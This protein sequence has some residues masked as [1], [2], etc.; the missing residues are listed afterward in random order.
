MAKAVRRHAVAAVA[1]LGASAIAVTPIAR[2]TPPAIHV[3]NL[4]TSLAASVA[5]TPVN[6]AYALANVP[7]NQVQAV[8]QLAASLFHSGT[9]WVGSAANV[10]GTDAADPGKWKSLTNLLVPFPAMSNVLGEQLAMIAAAELPTSDSCDAESCFPIFP[11]DPITG[12]TDLDRTIQVVAIAL[13]LKPLAVVNNWFQVPLSELMSG[14]TFPKVVSPSGPVY[15]GF[16][17]EGTHPDP[18]TGEPLMPWSGQTFTWHPLDPLV[19][20][21]NSL[22]ATPPP[23]ADA[24]KIVTGQQVFSAFQA[25]LAGIVV[26]F[27]PFVPGSPSCGACGDALWTTPE[28][29][30]FIGAHPRNALIDEWLTRVENGTVNEPTDA[31]VAWNLKTLEKPFFTFDPVTTAKINTLL[32][33]IHPVL[34]DIAAHSGLLAPADTPALLA[35]IERILG[36]GGSSD[37]VRPPLA[38]ATRLVSTSDVPQWGAAMPISPLAPDF[39]VPVAVSGQAVDNVSV[40]RALPMAG[41]TPDSE[42]KPGEESDQTTSSS[43]DRTAT[44]STHG[45]RSTSGPAGGLTGDDAVGTANTGYTRSGRTGTGGSEASKAGGR[46]RAS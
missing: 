8:N 12:I 26:D 43:I 10:W 29:V 30:K 31:Q 4:E 32:A 21:Y 45:H 9:W 18:D 2:P 38:A 1:L 23:P 6:L 16:G 28:I 3:A 42:N 39:A 13:G 37:T 15:E 46:H 35:D 5:N 24:I 14:Y 11:G 20:F 7:Y 25:L 44:D 40:T 33:D 36:I 22:T 17:F 27:N 19:A 34:P 41:Q